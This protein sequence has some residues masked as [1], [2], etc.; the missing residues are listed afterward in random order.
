MDNI[1]TIDEWKNILEKSKNDVQIVYKHSNTCAV[2]TNIQDLL[3][4][5]LNDD[6]LK[7][8][9]Y[10]VIV[11]DNRDVSDQIEKDLAL[12][13]ESPQLILI[14]NTEVLYFANHYDINIQDILDYI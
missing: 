7:H 4:S 2:C 8:K 6:K 1:T 5:V 10:K 14:K 11:H 13:H 3:N 12:K 9:I